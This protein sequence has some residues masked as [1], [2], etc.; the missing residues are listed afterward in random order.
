MDQKYLYKLDR[1][2]MVSQTEKRLPPLFAGQF[3]LSVQYSFKQL[4]TCSK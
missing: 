2:C 4:L 3:Y 1:Y